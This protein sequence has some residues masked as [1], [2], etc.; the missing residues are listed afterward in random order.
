MILPEQK[1][2]IL[3][4]I[5]RLLNKPNCRV[6]LAR[7]VRRTTQPGDIWETYASGQGQCIYI[8]IPYAAGEYYDTSGE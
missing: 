7:S 3:E 4:E 5:Q 8:E 6:R 1:K 2:M